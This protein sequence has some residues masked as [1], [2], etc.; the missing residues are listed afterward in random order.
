MSGGVFITGTDTGVGKTLVSA[1]LLAAL[2]ATGCRAVGMKPVASGCSETAD[3]LRND[4]AE[5]L[6][7]HSASSPDYRLVNSYALATPIAPHLAAA[8]AGTQIR[9]DP[10]VAAFATLSTNS[11][12]VVVEGVGGWAVPLSPT[13]MQADLVRALQLPVVLVVGLRLGCINHAL[14]SA[15]AIQNDGCA[16]LGWIG[17]GIDPAMA[18]VDDNIA[19]LRTRLPVPCLGVVPA[20]AH[21]PDPCALIAYLSEAV[22]VIASAACRRAP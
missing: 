6:I 5:R 10:I 12:C 18:R 4:D 20:S 8:D 16:L 13:L 2:N 7:A 9:L 22:S 3:G 11:D 1:T 17:N 14:L 15:R 21:E 19:T